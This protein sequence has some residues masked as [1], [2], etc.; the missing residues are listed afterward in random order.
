MAI[1]TLTD[2]YSN[3]D[4]WPGDL[5]T[6]SDGVTIGTKTATSF[7]FTFNAGTLFAGYSLTATGK[8]FAYD[9]TTPIDGTMSDFA[10]R[11]AG[12]HLVLSVSGIAANSLASDLSLLAAYQFGWT[13]PGGGGSTG[14]QKN[15]WSQLLSGN[16][17]YIGTE[18][19]DRRG[20]VGVDAG[21][22]VFNMGA[23]DDVV[24]G[25]LGDDTINGGDGWDRLSYEET[26]WNEGIPM[27]R[28]ITVDM[29]A[30][31]VLDPYG[32]TDHFTGL[33]EIFGSATRDVFKG[34]AAAMDF[35]GLR[36]ADKIIGGTGGDFAVYY[37]DTW[38]GGNRGIVVNLQTS[39]SGTDILGTIRDGFGNLDH[40]VNIFNVAGTIYR[41]SFTGSGKDDYF[42]GGEGKD[43]Y[44][45]KGG[46][47]YVNFGWTFGDS[48]QHGISVNLSKASG[49]IIDDGFGNTE[50]AFSIEGI[51]GSNLNDRI[52]G[53]TRDEDLRGRG[54]D[55]TLTGGGGRDIF[56]WRNFSEIGGHDVVTDFHAGVGTNRD[57]LSLNTTDWG[58]STTLH[59]VIG[60]AATQAVETF[61]FNPTTHL[62]SWDKDGTGGAAAISI[63]VLNN[64]SNLTAANFDLF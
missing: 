29:T 13:D 46:F 38:L 44:Y 14:Q 2:L 55:D 54:G 32:Y 59:L 18:G 39:T 24:N 20:M 40:T 63:A 42:A 52:I 31:T 21:N 51:S 53:S 41:D 28:G 6:A 27:V 19:N 17:T 34:G 43:V 35:A 50:S 23:G 45:G 37:E 64:V 8:G 33:E 12:G 61:I 57:V 10:I 22:D 16:D 60:A 56:I 7:A 58:G 4:H 36:G 48:S 1:V 9:G 49:Q 15:A 3:L 11:D 62:L 5:M 47:D 25:G 26:Q 30:G